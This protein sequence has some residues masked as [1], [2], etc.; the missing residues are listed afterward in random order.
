MANALTDD[1]KYQAL[2]E[3][4]PE[5]EGIFITGVKTTG[6]FC[7]TTCTA[8]KPKR[9]NVEFFPGVRDAIA[10]GYRPCKVCRPMEQPAATPDAIRAL[11]RELENDPS[12]RLKDYDLR[13]K[14]FEPA[15]LRRWF[16]KHHGMSFHAFQRMLRI[17]SA[18]KKI[19]QGA[20]V[21]GAAFEAGYESNSG[22]VDGF[23]SIFGLSPSQSKTAGMIDCKRIETPL[24]TM[25][26]CATS[27]GICLL[28]FSDRRMLETELVYL[29]KRLNA[30]ILQGSN[31]H[32]ELLEKELA[33]YFEGK[34]KT[35]TTP[36][37][38]IGSPFQ[39]E[40]WNQLLTIPFGKTRSYKEQAD[41]LGKPL[42]IRAVANANGLNKISI[43]VPCHRVIGSDGSLTGY[44]GGLWR[45]EKLLQ[46]EGAPIRLS[47]F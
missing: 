43:I 47:L 41:A 8:R 23:R 13:Q 46:L 3:K 16:L 26:A 34:L 19:Q 44:G 32:F 25:L 7:R 37:D 45:K 30:T 18:F 31:P 9:E 10:A 6:I 21:T 17:N 4:D 1:R 22:F 27:K 12:I 2:V 29:S 14:G 5:F 40:V 33:E 24:G 20:S 11:I 15:T 35:F 42:A 39:L 28:E 36:I 38:L